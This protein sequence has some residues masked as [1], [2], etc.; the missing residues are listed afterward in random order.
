MEVGGNVIYLEAGNVVD[1][2][3]IATERKFGRL[4]DI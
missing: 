4:W 3:Y 1:G 2:V